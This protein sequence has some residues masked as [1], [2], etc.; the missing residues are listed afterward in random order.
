MEYNPEQFWQARLEEK[1][2]LAGV[3][4]RRRGENFNRWVYRARLDRLQDVLAKHGIEVTGRRILDIGCGT[5]F[6][7]GFWHCFGPSLIKGVDITKKSIDELSQRYPQYVF[8]K[9]D[10]S[11]P[12]SHGDGPFDIITAFDV[13]FHIAGEAGFETAIANIRAHACEGS[14]VLLTGVFGRRSISVQKHY[15]ARSH[16]RYKDVLTGNGIE[17]LDIC[18]QLF[19]LNPPIDVSSRHLSY[20]LLSL[21]SLLTYPTLIEPVGQLLGRGLYIIDARMAQKLSSTLSTK[22]MVCRVES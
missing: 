10:I 13:L 1:F 21:W 17:I 14:Y 5:G 16:Q 4:L 7:I 8:E 3:G 15:F 22:I 11:Q 19:L 18:P 2:S 12:C 20:V 9:A 6:Y